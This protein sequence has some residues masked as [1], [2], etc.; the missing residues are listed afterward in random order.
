MLEVE[1]LPKVTLRI[2]AFK[3]RVHRR[4]RYARYHS[5]KNVKAYGCTCHGLPVNITNS[6][7]W[8]NP[9]APVHARA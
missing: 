8:M 2:R 5:V 6:S 4:L 9:S 1:I 7:E 3:Q